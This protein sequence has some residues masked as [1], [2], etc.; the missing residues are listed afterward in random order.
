MTGQACLRCKWPRMC[1]GSPSNQYRGPPVI[2]LLAL[3][4]CRC[5]FCAESVAGLGF[6]SELIPNRLQDETN[7]LVLW[8]SG[9]VARSLQTAAGMRLARASPET[10]NPARLS[11]I[12]NAHWNKLSRGEGR[13]GLSSARRAAPPGHHA[14]RAQKQGVLSFT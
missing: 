5:M 2:R 12:L 4:C 11:L 10:Q 1:S 3:V 6:L 14:C 8:V 9:F 7:S 13:A